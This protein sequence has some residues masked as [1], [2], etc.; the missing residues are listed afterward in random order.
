[1]V[2]TVRSKT[3]KWWVPT[4]TEIARRSDE[5]GIP[6]FFRRNRHLGDCRAIP[7]RWKPAVA[8]R[9]RVGKTPVLRSVRE[10]TSGP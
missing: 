7:H 2:Q 6:A 4:V 8:T 9:C 1:M 3:Y 5:R 10:A